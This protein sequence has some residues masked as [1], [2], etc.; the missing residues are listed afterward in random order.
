M[1]DVVVWWDYVDV[2]ECFF[3]LFDEVEVIFVVVIFDCVVFCECVWIEV[4]VFDGE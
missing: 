1:Y 2:F 4:V 3:C